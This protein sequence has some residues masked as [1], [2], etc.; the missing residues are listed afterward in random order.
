MD[1]SNYHI[2][3]ASRRARKDAVLRAAADS[4]VAFEVS[5]GEYDDCLRDDLKALLKHGDGELCRI[6]LL[7]RSISCD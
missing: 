4:E 5:A 6:P 2:L 7:S 3:F 1:C